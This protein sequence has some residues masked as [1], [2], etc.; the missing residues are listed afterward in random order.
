MLPKQIAKTVR[1]FTP[2]SIRHL[3]FRLGLF[4]GPPVFPD[5]RNTLN[6]LKLRGFSPKQAIDIGA[7]QGSWTETVIEIF[8]TCQYLM[9][10]AQE[11]K[12]NILEK[13]VL[14]N[15]Q[16]LT[17]EIALL[18]PTDG[19]E[20]TFFEMETGSS[21][22]EENSYFPR[23]AKVYHSKALD[24]IANT[25]H[26]EKCDILKLDVQGYEL[27]VL[28]GSTNLLKNTNIVIV[29]SSL[30]PVNKNCPLVAE[31]ISFMDKMNFQL[32]D[33]VSQIRRP[34]HVLWQ[35]DLMFIS[36][37]CELLPEAKYWH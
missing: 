28:R 37:N 23:K 13:A 2:N 30:I 36:R 34:D 33:I 16:Q 18:G 24:S 11:N 5:L 14:A 21:V 3:L 10:E 1:R 17:L 4:F 9:I 26:I 29:E 19:N 20:V 7:Y 22:L 6:A 15:P 25:H 31:V 27:E 12:R 8:P 35:L 32:Y